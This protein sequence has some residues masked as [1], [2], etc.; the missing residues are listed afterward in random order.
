[1]AENGHKIIYLIV[2]KGI[3]P[4]KQTY[5]RPAGVAYPCRDGSLNIKL[6]IHPLLIF[7]CRDPKS[8]GERDESQPTEEDDFGKHL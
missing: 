3:G 5:W 1:M 6:D 2:E 7:N 4:S 8:N